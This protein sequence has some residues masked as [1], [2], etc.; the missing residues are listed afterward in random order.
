MGF[1]RTLFIK[2][3]RSGIKSNEKLQ[4]VLDGAVEL[5][6]SPETLRAVQTLADRRRVLLAWEKEML[7]DLETKPGRGVGNVVWRHFKRVLE[8]SL[9]DQGLSISVK[10]NGAKEPFEFGYKN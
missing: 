1:I 7:T 9:V 10:I 2:N 3:M 5:L 8:Q 4:R 6:K